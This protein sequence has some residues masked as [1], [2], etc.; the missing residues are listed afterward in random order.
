MEL[1]ERE[2]EREVLYL[3]FLLS[4]LLH[5]MLRPVEMTCQVQKEPQ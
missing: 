1:G 2:R 3:Y 5:Q 4:V